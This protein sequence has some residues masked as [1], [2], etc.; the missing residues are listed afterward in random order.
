MC[1]KVV[2]ELL[3]GDAAAALLAA[4]DFDGSS[5]LHCAAHYGNVRVVQVRRG[6]G[7]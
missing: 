5:P 4:A 6:L 2:S 7:S 3:R 1:V